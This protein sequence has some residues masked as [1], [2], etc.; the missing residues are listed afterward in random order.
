[1]RAEW[2][3]PLDCFVTCVLDP[4][5]PSCNWSHRVIHAIN[6]EFHPSTSLSEIHSPR[7]TW[8]IGLFQGWHHPLLE[9]SKCL[10]LVGLCPTSSSVVKWHFLIRY[11]WIKFD[12]ESADILSKMFS[13]VRKKKGNEK[14]KILQ[15]WS[16]RNEAL[17]YISFL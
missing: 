10:S 2:N 13:A 7:S 16:Y 5:C 3:N 9:S 17:K 12:N 14:I 15:I 1:M 6:S 8:F 4:V 11:F